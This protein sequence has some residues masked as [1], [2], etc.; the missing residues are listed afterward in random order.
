MKFVWVTSDVGVP[1]SSG[2]ELRVSRLMSALAAQAHVDVLLLTQHGDAEA[3]RHAT[4]V[5]SV[6]HFPPPRRPV[7][8][9]V[10][11]AAHRW[12]LPTASIYQSEVM[13]RI[14]REVASGARVVVDHVIAAPYLLGDDAVLSTQNA[15]AALLRQLPAPAGLRGRVERWWDC[16]QTDRL[17]KSAVVTAGQVVCVTAEDVAAMAVRRGVV[18][19]NGCDLPDSWPPRPRAGSVLFVGSFSYPP[20]EDAVRWWLDEIAPLLPPGFPPLTVAGR[21][22]D[23]VLADLVGRA[24]VE[25][26]SDLPDLAPL[27]AASRVVVVPVRFG[28]G[29]RLKVLE[30]MA[31]GRPVV[32]THKG[33]EGFPVVDG[34]DALLA[35]DPA[36]I[37]E[38]VVLAYE[39][40]EMSTRLAEHGRAFAE[41][42]GWSS[43]GADFVRAVTA[44]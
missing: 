35:D 22:A 41:R 39:E 34:T 5:A 13:S 20:N 14:Q 16:R 3:L 29:S 24:G 32:S 43:L 33:V 37:A 18:I 26:Y 1:P 42:Y 36:A 10:L 7:L 19:P 15:E 4:G 9:R 31:W 30:G 25:V 12:P 40:S 8:R 11:A 27:L 21:G 44:R 6:T 28:G 23:K 2:G 17:E 38:A